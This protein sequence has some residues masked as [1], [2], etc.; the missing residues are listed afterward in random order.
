MPS[1]STNIDPGDRVPSGSTV[2]VG[3]R[4]LRDVTR[5][6]A[7]PPVLRDQRPA[8]GRDHRP[9][10]GRSRGD[11]VVV[12]NPTVAP[13]QTL[14][15]RVV[16]AIGAGELDE[17]LALIKRLATARAFKVQLESWALTGE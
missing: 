1:K 17:H 16:A 7:L 4:F 9:G 14:A 13:P 2:A 15:E 12:E 8:L 3:S 10:G 5:H 11:Q 6:P